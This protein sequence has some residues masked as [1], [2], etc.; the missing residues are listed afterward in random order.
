MSR[1]AQLVKNWSL[2]ILL[3]AQKRYVLSRCFY[4]VTE[5]TH[6]H[7]KKTK[8]QLLYLFK[9]KT[10]PSPPQFKMG[11]APHFGFKCNVVGGKAADAC[12][13]C[14]LPLQPLSPFPCPPSPKAIPCSKGRISDRVLD[15]KLELPP[16]LLLP[17]Q[18]WIGEKMCFA[19]WAGVWPELC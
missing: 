19:P 12:F 10:Q 13:S 3:G 11:G 1:K 8:K 17:S 14:L 18:A 9:S 15:P 5:F 6:F 7:N 16:L 2:W 4:I